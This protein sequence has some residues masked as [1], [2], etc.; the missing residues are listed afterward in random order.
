MHEPVQVLLD[1]AR[2]LGTTAL[3]EAVKTT[4]RIIFEQ[5]LAKGRQHTPPGSPAGL[6]LDAVA[7]GR[8]SDND[9]RTTHALFEA[10][11][12]QDATVERLIQRLGES[13]SN[14]GAQVNVGHSNFGSINNVQNNYTTH[15][16]HQRELM[17]TVD[18]DH[19]VRLRPGDRTEVQVTVTEE[20]RR[21]QLVNFHLAPPDT[22]GVRAEPN[23]LM[24]SSGGLGTTRVTVTVAAGDVRPGRHR[25]ELRA[26]SDAG[27]SVSVPVDV[28]VLEAPR[29]HTR[30]APDGQDVLEV[31]NIGNCDLDL[32]A[33]VSDRSNNELG[34]HDTVRLPV[35]Q[36]LEIPF[37]VPRSLVLTGVAHVR[38]NVVDG[39][40]GLERRDDHEVAVR[41]RLA[42]HR[43]APFLGGLA[44]VSVV[45][46]VWSQLWG[47][48]GQAGAQSGTPPRT[49]GAQQVSGMLTPSVCPGV[50]AADRA[51]ADVSPSP[52]PLR[53]AVLPAAVPG[54]VNT[55]L[56]PDLLVVGGAD[57]RV[58][59]LDPATLQ[60]LWWSPCLD[61]P[62]VAQPIV[63]DP[64]RPGVDP[65]DVFAVTGQ[66]TVYRIRTGGRGEVPAE[67]GARL[68]GSTT[69]KPTLLDDES[70]HPVITGEV[71]GAPR[72]SLVDRR[73]LRVKASVQLTEAPRQN[74]V[75]VD[76]ARMY[77]VDGSSHE[78]TWY[79][80]PSA[81][82]F[83]R[84]DSLEG[85][86]GDARLTYL[87]G[88]SGDRKKGEKSDFLVAA[89]TY[90][91]SGAGILIVW[92]GQG[93]RSSIV[94]LPG[95][96]AGQVR[97]SADHRSAHLPLR[98]GDHTLLARVDLTGTVT[99]GADV[100][101]QDLAVRGDD[102]GTALA[103]PIQQVGGD[104]NSLVLA[105]GECV[106]V[107]DSALERE[108]DVALCGNGA[109]GTPGASRA[110]GVLWAAGRDGRVYRAALP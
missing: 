92:P 59:A 16:T 45:L 44:L 62:V 91:S 73:T 54:G 96:P 72:I 98:Q 102:A 11:A 32:R 85:I 99:G 108:P 65:Y 7:A 60:E 35:G 10:L 43:R 66:G 8:P 76:G 55:S 37:R 48:S 58:H 13:V 80:S 36:K 17:L 89:G 46:V 26:Q 110:E 97:L 52:A 34:R 71:D 83:E 64:P 53:S 41:P 82:A 23:P 86:P 69:M 9:R 88:R 51:P 74:P 1:A 56:A 87:A 49:S 109:M 4:V 14:A 105:W 104:E 29:W 5:L 40:S 94:S 2:M 15:A 107:A 63:S 77:A 21:P 81:S 42:P 31:T 50:S 27:A 67:Q 84:Q 68:P 101:T 12:R 30:P 18:P 28:E 100:V 78:Q 95:E 24:L 70:G 79:W 93:R 19:P 90:G 39:R 57:R 75:I 6:A 38:L 47:P 22:L 61:G 20:A 103:T 3:P 106:Y 33:R 25:F